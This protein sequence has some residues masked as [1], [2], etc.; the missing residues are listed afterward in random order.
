MEFPAKIYFV[1]DDMGLDSVKQFD[2]T[3]Q[4]GLEYVEYI[5][6]SEFDAGK[7]AEAINA[8]ATENIRKIYDKYKAYEKGAN[9][10]SFKD[11]DDYRY[12]ML[13]LWNAIKL[14]LKIE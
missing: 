3:Y 1:N 9:K 6:L 11:Y 13:E 7:I 4:G 14:D 12:T 2:N 10:K 5:K 8:K